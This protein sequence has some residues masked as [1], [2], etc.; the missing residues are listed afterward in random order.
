M[1]SGILYAS[2]KQKLLLL[3]RYRKIIILT[4]TRHSAIL[5]MRKV[6]QGKLPELTQLG[7][8]QLVPVLAC[9]ATLLS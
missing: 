3:Q 7:M 4:A 6:R 1:M 5:Q 2:N 9:H 8:E